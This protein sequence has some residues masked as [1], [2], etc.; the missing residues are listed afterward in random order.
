[1]R[2]TPTH[3]PNGHGAVAGDLLRFFLVLVYLSAGVA[4]LLEQP[5]WLSMTAT[6]AASH[7]H[8]PHVR[9]VGPRFLGRSQGMVSLGWLL[10]H[11]HR[12]PLRPTPSDPVCPPLGPW[13]PVHAHRH[14]AHHVTRVWL[15]HAGLLS[16]ALGSLYSANVDRRRHPTN[17]TS[18]IASHRKRKGHPLGSIPP[19]H[20][21]GSC[22]YR[23]TRGRPNSLDEWP[24]QTRS[25]A[26][27]NPGSQFGE[28]QKGRGTSTVMTRRW[29]RRILH[30]HLPLQ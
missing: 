3:A 16:V 8:R 19:F 21:G 13:W 25:P 18:H 2:I 6:P 22:G 29:G 17:K 7:T 9:P 10:H 12:G 11:C 5:G 4:K 27:A 23:N 1:M 14:H 26:H 20:T 30:R 15:G 28:H 24:A